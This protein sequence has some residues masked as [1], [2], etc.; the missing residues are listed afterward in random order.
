LWGVD[1]GRCVRLTTSPP[2]VSRHSRQYASLNRSQSHWHPRPLTATDLLF[3]CR[4]SYLTGNMPV[5]L[6][7]LLRCRSQSQSLCNKRSFSQYVLVPNPILGSDQMLVTCLSVTV[8]SYSGALSDE[9]SGLSFASRSLV[10]VNM[11]INHLQ[12]S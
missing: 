3:I 10:I 8:L 11:Y 2:F 7:G 9:R 4:C 12:F 5:D 6:H 1:H